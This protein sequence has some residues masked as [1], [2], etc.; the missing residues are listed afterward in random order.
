MT[1]LGPVGVQAKSSWRT[2]RLSGDGEKRSDWQLNEIPPIIVVVITATFE[3]QRVRR[4]GFQDEPDLGERNVID[5]LSGFGWAVKEGHGR[6]L[7][8]VTAMLMADSVVVRAAGSPVF[9]RKLCT[10]ALT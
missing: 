10:D 9:G 7:F 2:N 6:R 4:E 5:R 1:S 3:E 8:L